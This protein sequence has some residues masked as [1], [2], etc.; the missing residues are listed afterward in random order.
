MK[1]KMSFLEFR[2]WLFIRIR[3]GFYNMMQSKKKK[4]VFGILLVG[5]IS[6]FSLRNVVWEFSNSNI[7]EKLGFIS[8]YL[9]SSILFVIGILLLYGH[10]FEAWKIHKGLLRLGMY[11]HLYE[12][13][14]FLYKEV[15]DK[16]FFTYYF[17]SIGISI[18]EWSKRKYAL[19]NVFNASISKIELGKD[20]SH[21]IIHGMSGKRD[22]TPIYIWNKEC[23]TKD[24]VVL[25]AGHSMHG[26]VEIPLNIYPHILIGGSTGSGKTLLLKVL[27]YQAIQS[28]YHVLIADFKGGVDFSKE[29][30]NRCIFIED[31]P[32]LIGQLNKILIELEVRKKLLVEAECENI[33]ELNQLEDFNLKRII[34]AC[35]ELAELFDTAGMDKEQKEQKKKIEGMIAT[36]ARLG[37]AFGIHLILST[38]RPDADI[39]PGQIKNNIPY[40]ICGRADSILSRII[41]D[42]TDA[43]E[44]IPDDIPGV[45]IN[46]KG[47]LFK[48]YLLSDNF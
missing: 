23:K 33:D 28:D 7:L 19:E 9:L 38:Q 39:V 11:N 44:I 48:G 16:I 5:L 43:A 25:N 17:E 40:R 34:F 42:N 15:F 46:H 47:D 12:A 45:F 20:M 26:C 32:S 10:V 3:V 30:K 4:I 31:I 35:D 22:F 13:P 14:T 21:I 1:Y 41:L 37:R 2:Y 8:A 27:L 36:I 18:E 24:A 29:W 6:L